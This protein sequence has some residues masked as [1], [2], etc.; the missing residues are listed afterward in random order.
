MKWLSI[1][2][3]ALLA[4]CQSYRPLPLDLEAHE[5]AWLTRAP[6]ADSVAGY[7]ARLANAEGT[8]AR[9]DATDGL[10]LAEAEVVALFFHPGL[11]RARL[12][13]GV[14]LATAEN[15]GI[16]QDPEL[17]ADAGRVLAS[18]SNPWLLGAGLSV[19]IPLSGRP[20]VER[21][22][23][24][25]RN[26]VALVEVVRHEWDVLTALR[27]R[28]RLLERARE[29]ALLTREYLERL[30]A[31]GAL[32]ETLA[33]A[34]EIS[35]L[36]ARLV[37]I[38]RTAK[39]AELL[40]LAHTEREAVAAILELL[41]LHPDTPL[42]LVT[43][44]VTTV[45]LPENTRE[46]MRRANPLLGLRCAEYAV[47][48]QNLRLEIRKQYP[49][50]NLGGS[51]ELEDGQSK[52]ALLF[53]LPLPLW[54]RNRQGI[55]RA[56]AA[57]LASRAAF[58]EALEASGHALTLAELRLRHRSEYRQRLL[59]TV[60]P[61]TDEQIQDARRLADLG[62]FEVLRQLEALSRQHAT[63]VQVL[64]AAIE[65]ARARDDVLALAGPSFTFPVP[66]DK[67]GALP[68][69]TQHE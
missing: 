47:A 44:G 9:F 41:G 6:E 22:L 10:S 33:G 60:V 63:R 53:G 1:C 66:A 23:A 11:R 4:G 12:D 64:D 31:L 28:W 58:E 3:A 39:E 34:G 32:A 52:V 49:D 51:Y 65:V 7:A 46:A 21:D 69:D 15:A 62:D 67:P 42:T 30:A 27:A 36:D 25:A 50:L 16:W 20:G 40:S 35:R 26:D 38:E 19:T 13:A 56:E 61:L 57:R 54:N 18:V 5:A 17:R 55:A 48:E 24:H 45:A 14:E 43:E 59:E 37:A 68:E 2:A 8:A 29:G